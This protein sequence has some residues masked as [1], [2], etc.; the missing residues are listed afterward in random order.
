[1]LRKKQSI[2]K[3]RVKRQRSLLAAMRRRSRRQNSS[4]Y[5][6]VGVLTVLMPNSQG[7]R[8]NEQLGGLQSLA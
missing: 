2:R 5:S 4:L 1:M 3:G 7:S 6:K 8:S